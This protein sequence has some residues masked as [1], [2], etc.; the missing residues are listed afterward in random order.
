MSQ[1]AAEDQI[2]ISDIYTQQLV[3][4]DLDLEQGNSALLKVSAPAA[5]DLPWDLN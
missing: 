4:V 5:Q 3:R 2:R 1:T